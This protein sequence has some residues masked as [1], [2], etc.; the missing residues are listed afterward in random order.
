MAGRKKERFFISVFPF[1]NPVTKTAA[2]GPPGRLS[3]TLCCAAALFG[4]RADPELRPAVFAPDRLAGAGF[5]RTI[6]AV[7]YGAD[8]GEIDAMRRQ[9]IFHRDIYSGEQW[10]EIQPCGATK[11]QAIVALKNLLDCDRV[12]C[13]GDGKNDISMFEIADACYAMENADPALKAIATDVIG[14]NE[15]DGVARWLAEHIQV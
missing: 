8:A 2:S 1:K 7:T 6:L 11:A 4:R 5:R 12:V 9:C 14:S 3:Q 10:L 15:Q 13:F